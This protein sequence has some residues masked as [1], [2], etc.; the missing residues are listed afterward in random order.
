M[1]ATYVAPVPP[2]ASV[3]SYAAPQ[4]HSNDA[5]GLNAVWEVLDMVVGAWWSGGIRGESGR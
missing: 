1:K 4:L 2:D 3:G 5:G